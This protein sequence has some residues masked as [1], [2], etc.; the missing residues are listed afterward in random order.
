MVVLSLLRAWVMSYTPVGL[1][2]TLLR[3]GV[4]EIFRVYLMTGVVEMVFSHLIDCHKD[5]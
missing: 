4:Y 3:I 2:G 5:Q 1:P